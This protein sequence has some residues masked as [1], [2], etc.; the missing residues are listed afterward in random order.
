MDDGNSISNYIISHWCD[1]YGTDLRNYFLFSFRARPAAVRGMCLDVFDDF[2][3]IYIRFQIE[4][5]FLFHFKVM[6]LMYVCKKVR[7]TVS[8]IVG[9]RDFRHTHSTDT[10]QDWFSIYV[11]VLYT[12]T[13]V[14]VC[15]LSASFHPRLFSFFL[16]VVCPFL[17]PFLFDAFS[18]SRENN[19]LYL[20]RLEFHQTFKVATNNVFLIITVRKWREKKTHIITNKWFSQL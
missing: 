18:R 4:S 19:I 8:P 20:A 13:S 14:C 2:V 10:M 1:L 11:C 6:D 17:A 7:F 16:D 12:H 3:W 9:T 5:I 15:V